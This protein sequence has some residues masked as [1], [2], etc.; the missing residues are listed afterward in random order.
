[1]VKVSVIIP[2]YNQAQFL[3]EAVDSVLNQTY[4]DFEII[5]VDDGSFGNDQI[6][7]L[8]SFQKE[9]T[10]LY[11][12]KNQG[13]EKSRNFAI[14]K[15]S[16][17][18]ILPLDADDKIAPTYLEKAIQLLDSDPNLGIVYCK[19]EYFGSRSGPMDINPYNFP[20]ILI[21]PQIFV[22][23]FF[24]KCDWLRAGKFA[25]DMVYGWEDYDFWLTIHE[26]G[27]TAK[28]I[29]ETLF[30][31]RQIEG[32][33][34]DVATH[35]VVKIYSQLFRKHT[36]LYSDN[37]EFIFESLMIGRNSALSKNLNT[38]ELVLYNELDGNLMEKKS[39]RQPYKIDEKTSISIN[40]QIQENTPTSNFIR[41]DPCDFPA[42]I[43]LFS[44]VITNIVSGY[45][46]WQSSNNNNFKNLKLAGT[47][48]RIET[49]NDDFSILSTGTDPQI[50]LLNTPLID[51]DAEWEITITFKVSKDLQLAKDF[52]ETTK[53]ISRIKTIFTQFLK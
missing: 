43:Q 37:I 23:A 50:L 6:E 12:N 2:C 29:D 9:K 19:A 15:A 52:I 46:V 35:K 39:I 25:T 8:D 7:I 36:K 11:R 17:Q 22:S 4:Q 42:L 5:I 21:E 28:Q 32:S 3:S 10:T 34:K 45:I 31:Y 14:E 24:R 49:A 20:N 53:K 13:V 26:L 27:R 18:Y 47:S 1:M 33:R 48:T 41:I 30:Y 40:L 51:S 16:G 44:V 38:H